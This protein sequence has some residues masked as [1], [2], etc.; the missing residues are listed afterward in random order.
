[1]VIYH[2]TIKNPWQNPHSEIHQKPKK[3]DGNIFG[4]LDLF[5]ESFFRVTNWW[6]DQWPGRSWAL[7]TNKD[8]P[9]KRSMGGVI[10]IQ[11]DIKLWF[12]GNMYK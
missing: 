8:W 9:V 5:R 2:H 7:L 6:I 4:D 12:L 10:W 11:N 1:M 3:T